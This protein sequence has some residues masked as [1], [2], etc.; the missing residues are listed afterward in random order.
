MTRRTTHAVGQL[1]V[2]GEQARLA[3]HD[4]LGLVGDE[5]VGDE[6]LVQAGRVVVAAGLPLDPGDLGHRLVVGQGLR[7][8]AAATESSSAGR[9]STSRLR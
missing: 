5:A 6:R 1:D 9:P 3:D 7:R 8:R 2:D 4:R